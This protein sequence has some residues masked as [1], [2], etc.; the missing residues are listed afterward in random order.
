MEQLFSAIVF[1]L[2]VNIVKTIVLKLRL[3]PY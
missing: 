1:S 3:E 2:T